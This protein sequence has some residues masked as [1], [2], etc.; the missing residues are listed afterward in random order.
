MPQK[1]SHAPHS[2]QE[3]NRVDQEAWNEEDVAVRACHQA[4]L[5]EAKHVHEGQEI[6]SGCKDQCAACPPAYFTDPCT[7]QEEEEDDCKDKEANAKG[8]G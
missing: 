5:E 4:H 8:H 2:Q 7:D 3:R 1:L 6:S